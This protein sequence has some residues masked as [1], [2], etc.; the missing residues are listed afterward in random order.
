MKIPALLASLLMLSPLLAVPAAGQ[1]PL[2]VPLTDIYLAGPPDKTFELVMSG[3]TFNLQRWPGIQD[4]LI[5]EANLGERLQFTVAVPETAEAH[6][7]HL[8][9]HPWFAPTIGRT[10]D[11]WLLQP[12]DVHGFTIVAG[13]IDQHDGDWMFHCHFASHAADGMWGI[14][15]VYPFTTSAAPTAAG[16]V[17]DLQRMGVPVNGAHLSI[18][19]D[20]VAIPSPVVAQEDGHYLLHAALPATGVLVVHAHSPELGMS[21]ARIGLGGADVPPLTM[22]HGAMSM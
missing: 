3:H 16:L 12:G 11:T 6:T 2:Q 17:V 22:A 15:R 19:V 10:V 8:H 1:F 7:F 9:G 14:L 21:V 4:G 5:L 13:G 18:E 20:G